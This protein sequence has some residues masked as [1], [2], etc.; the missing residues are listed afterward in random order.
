ML[1]TVII[2]SNKSNDRRIIEIED[3]NIH[4]IKKLLSVIKKPDSFDNYDKKILIKKQTENL[5][6]NNDILIYNNPEI[7]KVN[8]FV[9]KKITK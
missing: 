4:N 3:S 5:S 1:S 6:S 9:S 7:K 8:F 2:A